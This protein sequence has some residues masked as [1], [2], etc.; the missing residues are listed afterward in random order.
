MLQSALFAKSKKEIS[1]DIKAISHKFLLK[2]DFIEEVAGGIYNFLPL[3]W[4]VHRKIEE[5][6]REEMFNLGAQ[7]VYLSALI[8]K[9]L[10][11]KTQRWEKIDPPLFKLRDR[12]KSEFGLGSTHEEVVTLLVLGRIKSYKDLPLSLFQIQ[13]KFRNEMRPTGG[14][15]RMREFIMKDLYSFH[16]TEKE[17]NVFYQRVKKTYFSIFEKLNLDPLCVEADPGTIGGALSHEFMVISDTGEDKIVICKKCMYGANVE[18]LK[19]VKVCPKCK[20][21]LEK[22]NSI[23]IAHIFYLGTKYSKVFGANF[24]DK[25]GRL[26][27]I[28]MGCYGIGLPRLLAAVVEV[29]HDKKGIVWPE[30]IAPFSFHLIP[31]FSK[32]KREDKKIEKIT[33][34]IYTS[35][36]KA[37]VEVLYDDRKDKSPGEKFA[38][39]DLIGIPKRIV[40]SK[41]TLK[42]NCIEIKERSS[43]KAKLVKI[44]NLLK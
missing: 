18:K 31:V 16:A 34:K 26:Y 38:D 24:T 12:H 30:K 22:K 7:E 37:R 25:R 6:I 2:G 3:G 11:Q 39:S 42:E 17:A 21:I 4:R 8:P 9:S 27:P 41:T 35:L 1:K 15:L 28:I 13:D 36:K 19:D 14:L 29:H 32:N 10:W 5:I 44:R 43:K 33:E 20:G 23:E 40:V